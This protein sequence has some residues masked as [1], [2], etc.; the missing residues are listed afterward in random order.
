MIGLLWMILTRV[1]SDH[2]N[3]YCSST[4][5][6]GIYGTNIGEYPIL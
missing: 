2:Y 6:F 1:I 5:P 3:D 4:N